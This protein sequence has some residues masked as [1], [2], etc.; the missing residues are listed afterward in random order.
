MMLLVEGR[1]D[2]S[3][4]KVE[5]LEVEGETNPDNTNI[6]PISPGMSLTLK[7]GEV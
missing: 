6:R 7:M 3:A 1:N 4:E 5:Y 2:N